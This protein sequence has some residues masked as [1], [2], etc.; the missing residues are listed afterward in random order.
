VSFASQAAYTH[1]WSAAKKIALPIGNAIINRSKNQGDW[2]A[3]FFVDSLAEGRNYS[4]AGRRTA[5]LCDD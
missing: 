4:I 3:S 2:H 1:R 5:P